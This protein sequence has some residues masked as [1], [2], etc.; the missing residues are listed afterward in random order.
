M[1]QDVS[2]KGFF[3]YDPAMG[4]LQLAHFGPES[5]DDSWYTGSLTI[6]GKLSDF[7]LVYAGG[8]MKRTSH[9][10]AEYSDYSEF[11]D[12]IF[13]SGGYWTGNNGNPIMPEEF[14]I[15]GGYFEKWSHEVRLSTPAQNPVRATVGLFVQRQLHD[16]W[17]DYTMPGYNGNPFGNN[18]QGFAAALSMPTLDNNTIWLTD[19]QRV[20]RDQAAFAQVTWDMNSQW[21]LT[22]GL[23]YY[24]YDNSLQ[25]FFGYSGGYD[26]LLGSS[27]GVASCF[28]PAI[29]PD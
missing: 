19:E 22:G 27:S 4:D 28:A 24:K 29:L 8:Y 15:G 9:A 14:V 16:I 5:S 21:A 7:D 20:D 26:A 1:A 23:R 3:A 17:Q 12:K 10:I 13:G 18:P 6:E 25:G 11:Y 2:T